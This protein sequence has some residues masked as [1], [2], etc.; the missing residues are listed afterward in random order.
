MDSGI[1]FIQKNT[2]KIPNYQDNSHDNRLKK[3]RR[4]RFIR[5]ISPCTDDIE[6]GLNS[7]CEESRCI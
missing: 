4:R 6:C 5:V 1:S 7:R 3:R 2:N